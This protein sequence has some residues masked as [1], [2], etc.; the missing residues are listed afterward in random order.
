LLGI[1]PIESYMQVQFVCSKGVCAGHGSRADREF[2]SH[3]GHG[4]FD[5]LC[6]CFFLCLCIETS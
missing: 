6:M 5:F 1:H 4:C 2:E 3:S